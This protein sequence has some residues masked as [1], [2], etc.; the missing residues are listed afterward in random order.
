MAIV[1]FLHSHPSNID[2]P[3]IE[4]S[5]WIGSDFLLER[6]ALAERT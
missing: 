4:R 3:P 6:C 2:L 5:Q 1:A